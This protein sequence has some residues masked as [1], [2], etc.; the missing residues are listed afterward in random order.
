MRHLRA[1]S[2]LTLLPAILVTACGDDESSPPEPATTTA[3]A[4]PVETF[5]AGAVSLSVGGRHECFTTAT[6][7]GKCMGANILGELGVGRTL[8]SAAL[9]VFGLSS[10]LTSLVAGP[11]HTCGITDT[12]GLKCWGAN[13]DGQL[14]NGDT[15]ERSVPVDVT[16]LTT[17][18]TAV[19]LGVSH[20]C[21]VINSDTVQCWGKNDYGQLG[22]DSSG[23]FEDTP[24]DVPGLT[25]VQAVVGG[26]THSCALLATGQVQC[27]GGY[28]NGEIGR[29]PAT[30]AE[31]IQP[32]TVAGIENIT[33][34][35]A[36]SHHT[37]ALSNNG[38]ILCWGRNIYGQLGNGTKTSTH[39]PV[40]SV[41]SAATMVSAGASHTCAVVADTTGANIIQCWGSNASKQLGITSS[42]SQTQPV[43][44]AAVTAAD[45]PTAVGSGWYHTCALLAEGKIR[46]WG[47]SDFGQF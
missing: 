46:C 8:K 34:L 39:E 17:G 37:C 16:G 22:H 15:Y 41:A 27:W 44:C 26:R 9:D 4:V 30:T 3:T 29:I 40:T 2:C 28:A 6:G 31:S 23:A 20:T 45:A 18:V 32:V 5:E 25:G 47:S 12:G 1:V 21:A 43:I 33:A 35:S 24:T 10:G 13:S 38:A 36:G 7:G 19:G 11:L 42:L 14:G